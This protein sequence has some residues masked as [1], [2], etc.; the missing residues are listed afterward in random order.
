MKN[1]KFNYAL[2]DKFESTSFDA[3]VLEFWGERAEVQLSSMDAIA[4]YIN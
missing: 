1:V 4:A 2:S 3:E